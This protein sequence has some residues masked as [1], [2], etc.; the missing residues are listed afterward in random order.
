MPDSNAVRRLTAKWTSGGTSWPQRLDWIAIRGIRGWT[1]QRFELRYPI[2]AL[3]GENGT[4]KSTILQAAASVY[5][6]PVGKNDEFRASDFFLDTVWESIRKAEISYSARQ[7]TTTIE[8]SLRKLTERWRGNEDRPSRHVQYIDLSRIQP[9][10]AR[11]GYTMLVKS[12]AKEI[13]ATSFDKERLMRFSHVMGRQYDAARMALVA[14]HP[15]RPVPVLA[16]QGTMYSGFHGGA[17]ETTVAELLQADI[18]QYSIVLI[19]EIETSLHPRAQRRLIR[20]LLD[21]CREREW[22]VL[23]TTHSTF[24][25]EELPPEARAYIYQSDQN[26]SI[27]YGVSPEFAMTKTD[28]VARPECDIYVEDARAKMLLTEILFAHDAELLDRCQLVAY[29]PASVGNALGQ[30]I[31]ASR[32]PRPSRVFL[33]GDQ[34]PAPGCVNLPGDDAPERVVF[35]ALSARDWN[36]LISR[37]GRPS[38]DVRD[39][40]SRA[41]TANDHHEWVSS[42]AS[43]LHLGGDTLWQAMCSEWS[44][45]YLD[46]QQAATVVDAIRGALLG[47]QPDPITK[48]TTMPTEPINKPAIINAVPPAPSSEIMPLFGQSPDDVRE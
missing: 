18:P 20:D 42:A 1:G 11:V 7:G 46:K 17:G 48:R 47:L 8:K 27:I 45:N 10:S 29:G 22:Q 28:D 26:R 31:V 19:D 15:E 3:V 23:L 9:V 16:Q 33:D 37:L 35:G 13:S 12:H 5:Q 6:S 32:F 38:S 30:M 41:M 34:A 4:G 44:T 25:L 21:K 24:V 43:E 36:G 2:M 40:C 39:A 14:S